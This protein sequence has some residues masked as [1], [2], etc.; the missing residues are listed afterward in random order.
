MVSNFDVEIWAVCNLL[1]IPL[2]TLSY[3]A[4]EPNKLVVAEQKQNTL[5]LCV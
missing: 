1:H 5:D 2:Q 3:Q 4:G